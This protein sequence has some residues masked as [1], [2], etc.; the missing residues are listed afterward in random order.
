MSTEDKMTIDERYKYLR[1][2]RKRYLEASRKE[3]GQLLDEMEAVTEMHRKSLIRL[4]G[5]S[6][7]RKERQRQ[8]GRTYGPE[9]AYALTIIAE[10][11]DYPCAERLTPNLVWMAEHLA[12]HDELETS[13]A[14]LEKLGQI[15]ISTTQRILAAIP[16]EKPR[17]P[18][19]GPR[20]A[21]RL[22]QDIPMKRIPWN[23]GEPGHFEVDL[24]HPDD[25][26]GHRLERK[27]GGVGTQLAGDG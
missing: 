20:R 22:T 3:R 11:F 24:V 8:R 6:L 2:M 25:R 21:N 10:S 14:L 26:C 23:E 12:A 5:G 9:V 19:R 7:E 1:R 4:M 18:R 16:R 17:L 13:P 15:S 27:S